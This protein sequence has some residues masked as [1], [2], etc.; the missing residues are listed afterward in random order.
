[1]RTAPLLPRQ[2]AG[3]TLVVCA[4]QFIDEQVGFH[5]GV[6]LAGLHTSGRIRREGGEASCGPQERA[7]IETR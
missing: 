2:Q 1:M 6:S 7:A 4:H 5:R 3:D